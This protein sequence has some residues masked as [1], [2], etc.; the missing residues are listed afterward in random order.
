M[1]LKILD[2]ILG[3]LIERYNKV[4]RG[5]RASSRLQLTFY[6]RSKKSKKKKKNGNLNK[7]N[8]KSLKGSYHAIRENVK[9]L[10]RNQKNIKY[11]ESFLLTK[12]AKGDKKTWL[13]NIHYYFLNFKDFRHFVPVRECFYKLLLNFIFRLPFTQGMINDRPY[14]S[15]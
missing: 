14:F 1:R 5:N 13:I 7:N 3:T 9:M 2:R 11:W 12:A 15:F 6:L 4:T 8:E 10:E